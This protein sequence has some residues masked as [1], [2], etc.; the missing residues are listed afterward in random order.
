MA[1]FL[2]MELMPSYVS[3][4]MHDGITTKSTLFDEIFSLC[5]IIKPKKRLPRNVLRDCCN[6]SSVGQCT[7]CR[8]HWGQL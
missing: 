1:D 2:R 4:C 3:N 7:P 6:S 5:A 8:L